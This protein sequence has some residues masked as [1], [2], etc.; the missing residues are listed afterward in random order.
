MKYLFIICSVF[1]IIMSGS[2]A[3]V[4]SWV[5]RH[6]DYLV[7]EPNI[8]ILRAE[9]ALTAV[10]AIGGLICLVKTLRAFDRY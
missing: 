1:L 2:W 5:L 6:G 3:F 10:L 9:V 7:F 4:M 8:H